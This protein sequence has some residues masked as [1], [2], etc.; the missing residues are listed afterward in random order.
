MN[1]QIEIRNGVTVRVLALG[2]VLLSLP[3]GSGPFRF[4]DFRVP[5]GSGYTRVSVGSTGQF[6]FAPGT[7]TN[8]VEKITLAKSGGGYVDLSRVADGFAFS[9]GES[10]G[11][12]SH[13]DLIAPDDSVWRITIAADGQFNFAKQ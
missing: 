2:P 4:I 1:A 6:T 13:I 10:T 8:F 7:G 11:S 9:P 5:G 12:R 3:A